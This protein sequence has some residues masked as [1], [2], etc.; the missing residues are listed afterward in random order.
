[1]EIPIIYKIIINKFIQTSNY[2][3]EIKTDL[4]NRILSNIFR[5]PHK[6]RRCVLEEMSRL[7]LVKLNNSSTIELLVERIELGY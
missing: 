4:A 6:K 1:M 2:I 3:G 7:G 5:V